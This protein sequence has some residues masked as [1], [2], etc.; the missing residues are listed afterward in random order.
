MRK[1]VWGILLAAALLTTSVP[2]A[3]TVC[4]EDG[5]TDG[6]ALSS[7]MEKDDWIRGE[8]EDFQD[9]QS[10][11]ENVTEFSVDPEETI[12]DAGGETDE[13]KN[14]EYEVKKLEIGKTYNIMSDLQPDLYL[15]L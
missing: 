15:F 8:T 6:E 10:L 14:A 13:L 2:M 7:Q 12:I 3:S 9:E 5:F 4:A 1:K 11:E